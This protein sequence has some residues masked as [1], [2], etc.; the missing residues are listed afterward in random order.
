MTPPNCP[1][2]PL[3]ITGN[4]LTILTFLLSLTVAY[5]TLTTFTL[6]APREIAS[7]H[8]SLQEIRTQLLPILH[9]Y[10]EE[11]SLAPSERY[12]RDGVLGAEIQ[13]VVGMVEGLEGELVDLEGLG[14]DGDG[15]NE[16]KGWGVRRR[17]KWLMVR[18]EVLGRMQRTERGKMEVRLSQMGLLL[19]QVISF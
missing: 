6:S 15:G 1:D 10:S 2:S 14:G 7:L 3:T 11:A 4:A 17:V 5:L 19:R 18:R 12:D 8:L 16:R 9:C 13:R